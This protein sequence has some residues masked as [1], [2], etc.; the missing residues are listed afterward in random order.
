MKRPATVAAT[1]R[2]PGA[3]D[4]G[5][6]ESGLIAEA[7]A[8][9]TER[10]KRLPAK[11]LYDDAGC[12]LF[13]RITALPEYYPTRTEHALL[14]RVAAELQDVVGSGGALVEYGAS[15]EA[16]ALPLL[17]ALA[18][19]AYVPIDIAAPGLDALRAR[20]AAR[21]PLLA[22][23]PVAADFTDDVTLPPAIEAM[24]RLGFFP[25]STIGNFDPPA[26]REFLD[27]ARG[28]LGEGGRML[29]GVDLEKE[30]QTL[31]AAYDDAEG[32]T[33]RFNLNLLARLNREAGAQFDLDRFA[34]RVR[35]NETARR[36][37]MHLESLAD[38]IVEV[39]GTAIMFHRGETIHTE[40][41]YK[42]T[43]DGF[44]ALAGSAGWRPVRSWCDPASLFAEILLV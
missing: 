17:D 40:N 3:Q 26:A 23:H 15:D 31:V 35:W 19:E 11:L 16:K 29:V 7:L 4:M 21:R 10:Q 39:A 9:L 28:A 1:T 37:E 18:V 34:H 8:G 38:Q 2:D 14:G 25:G 6:Q 13:T 32:V 12:A 41:S 43:E 27:R 42:F 36:I 5:A 22:V 30:R 20:M 44:A 24:P 33:A